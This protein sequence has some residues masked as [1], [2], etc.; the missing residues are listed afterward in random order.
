VPWTLLDA[1]SSRVLDA[2]LAAALLLSGAAL[3]VAVC[4]QPARRL[5]LGR[6]A[7]VCAAAI[8]PWM[9]AVSPRVH[10]STLE[11]LIHPAGLRAATV[12]LPLEWLPR[13]ALAIAAAGLASALA[14]GALA[15]WAVRRLMRSSREPDART[16]HILRTATDNTPMP[17]VRV[18]D[19]VRRPLVVGLLRPVIVIP[20]ALEHVDPAS[21]ELALLHE[22]IHARRGDSRWTFLG[23]LVQAFWFFLPP[24]AWLREQMR[25]DQEYMVDHVAARSPTAGGDYAQ[26]LVDAT[27]P[28]YQCTAPPSPRARGHRARHHFQPLAAR[29]AMLLRPPTHVEPRPSRLWRCASLACFAA[30]SLAASEIS[31]LGD[32]RPA[33]LP[34]LAISASRPVELRI[35]LLVVA[36]RDARNP[37]NPQ[38]LLAQ[39]P[40]RFDMTFSMAR[41]ALHQGH[42]RLFGAVLRLPPEIDGPA[43]SESLV[44]VHVTRDGPR[45]RVRIGSHA[46]AAPEPGHDA[47]DRL[48]IDTL[49]SA[50]V[51]LRDIVV[52]WL[53]PATAK[54]AA[55]TTDSAPAATF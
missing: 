1:L 30:A 31:L 40:D 18:S 23:A 46:L 52:R 28:V 2:T 19:R 7:L 49:S 42:L 51:S 44:P 9:L 22:A 29:L 14:R 53:P 36:P 24:V 26:R 32:A 27:A 35:P 6:L 48:A 21:L 15:A 17:R 54:P 55:A 8:V 47:L 50:P 39:L 13:V 37:R 34:F 25:I 11:S 41:Y 33:A 12:R 38:P 45:L 3:A 10:L 16:I 4:R 43:G 5:F 20:G